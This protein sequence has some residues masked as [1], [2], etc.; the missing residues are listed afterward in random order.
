MLDRFALSDCDS[1]FVFC[2]FVF[3]FSLTPDS[4]FVEASPEPYSPEE[5]GKSSP[6]PLLRIPPKNGETGLNQLE[7][8][9]DRVRRHPPGVFGGDRGSVRCGMGG[10][11]VA[12]SEAQQTSRPGASGS[13]WTHPTW[14]DTLVAVS[15][16]LRTLPD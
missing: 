16:Q 11:A 6:L 10:G 15:A 2:F 3:F 4:E 12:R 7:G 8:R 1:V 5:L 13:S 9:K 14:K